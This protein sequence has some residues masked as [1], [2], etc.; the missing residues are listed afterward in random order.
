[1]LNGPGLGEWT[2]KIWAECVMNVTYLSNIIAT[3]SSLK[4]PFELSYGK[5]PTCF[6]R[7][8]SKSQQLMKKR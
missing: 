4:C 3:K 7:I 5:R 6:L 2:D 1:M 8:L